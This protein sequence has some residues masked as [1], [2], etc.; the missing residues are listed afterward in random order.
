MRDLRGLFSAYR[1][2]QNRNTQLKNRIHS[3]VK[4]QLYGFTQEEIFERK[5]RAKIRELSAEA[6][7]KF[8]FNQLTDRLERDEADMAALKERALLH[9][10]PFIEQ[11]DLLT[12]MKGG[13][14]L[15]SHSDCRGY[16]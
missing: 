11:I 12:G 16:H 4:G 13:E 6:V 15:H 5:S 1:L 9:A 10:R 3:L 14:R 2:Y 8:Q 7:L